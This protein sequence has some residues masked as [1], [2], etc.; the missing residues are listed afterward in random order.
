MVFKI[1]ERPNQNLINILII[2][3]KEIDAYA[4][5]FVYTLY[6]F[7]LKAVKFVTKILCYPLNKIILY[8]K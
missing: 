7:I 3:T 2:T 1:Q 8:E 4:A 5:C 6:P